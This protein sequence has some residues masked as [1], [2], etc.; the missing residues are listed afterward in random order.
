MADVR[1]WLILS[2]REAEALRAAVWKLGERVPWSA[3]LQRA[4]R[5]IDRQLDWI[6]SGGAEGL[7]PD[8]SNA[9]IRDYKETREHA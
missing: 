1:P 2:R 6:H 4:M 8:V 5:V 7:R 3:D 9:V